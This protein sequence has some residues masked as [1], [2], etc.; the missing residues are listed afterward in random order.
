M[1]RIQQKTTGR[2][3]KREKLDASAT[4]DALKAALDAKGLS[5]PRFGA[6]PFG[7]Q[8]NIEHRTSNIEHRTQK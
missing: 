3:F 1:A 7:S 8:A 2:R 6:M 4:R 5:L